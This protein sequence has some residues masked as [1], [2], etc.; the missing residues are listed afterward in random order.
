M[1]FD[2]I[3][4]PIKVVILCYNEVLCICSSVNLVIIDTVNDWSLVCTQVII[5]TNID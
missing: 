5:T 3:D 4:A 1:I 2:C